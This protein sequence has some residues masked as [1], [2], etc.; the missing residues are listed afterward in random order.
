M[1]TPNEV[2]L[3]GCRSQVVLHPRELLGS[4]GESFVGRATCKFEKGTK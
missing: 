2:Y 1:T 3:T 4:T